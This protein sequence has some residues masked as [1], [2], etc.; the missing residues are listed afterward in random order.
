MDSAGLL[1]HVGDD[2]IGEGVPD[3]GVA[4][5]KADLLNEDQERSTPESGTVDFTRGPIVI[6]KEEKQKAFS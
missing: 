2:P 6:G 3:H 5:R 1:A 4:K